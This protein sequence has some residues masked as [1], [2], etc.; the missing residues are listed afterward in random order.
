MN[1]TWLDFNSN[2]GSV[3]APELSPDLEAVKNSIQ[4]ILGTPIGSRPFQRDYGSMLHY[5]IH[6]PMDRITEE[7]IRVSIIQ[8][9]EKWE[10]RITIDARRTTVSKMPNVN[11]Y[12]IEV[13]FSV[14][15]PKIS[16]SVR[17]VTKRI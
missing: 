7:Q 3:V 6:Q 15:I 4:N 9:L 10:P 2:Y 12:V 13:Y 11:G 14:N 1:S 5:F 16:G 17:F 8:A